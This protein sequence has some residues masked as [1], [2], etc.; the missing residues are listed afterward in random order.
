M[1]E[2]PKKLTEKLTERQANNALR[3]LPVPN[4]LID[5]SSNDY[6]GFAKNGTIFK[7][8]SCI[9][10]KKGINDNGASG[11]RLLTG[12][13]ELYGELED[14]LA[15]FFGSGAALIFNSGYDAN[16]GFFSAVPQRTDV[17]FYDELSHAS[18]RDGIGLGR[19]QSFKFKHNS[20]E[21]LSRQIDRVREGKLDSDIYVVTESVFSMDGDSPDLEAFVAL[22]QTK[23]AYLV[24]DEAHAVGV[25]GRKGE[26]LIY[27]LGLQDK[28]FARIV[29]FG[30]AMGCHG[31]AILGSDALKSYLVN[32]ARSFIYTTGMPP[33][34]LATILSACEHVSATNKEQNQLRTNI[35]FFKSELKVHNLQSYFIPSNSAVH[36]CLVEGNEKVKKWSQQLQE[37]G[38]DIKPIMSPTVP[39]GKER[40]RFCLHSFNTE[41]EINEVLLQLSNLF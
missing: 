9:L 32:F 24:I 15:D 11:S 37:N 34:S 6:L 41:Q 1:T 21:D 17:V 14:L 22:C 25:F 36:C 16:I 10:E 39:K 23:G 30:K 20:V 18:I 8:T 28:V 7:N 4:G 33:H 35:E 29:T 12:N 31:A 13:S 38:F 3:K 2:F 5:F 40:L 19:A 27:E 26:G